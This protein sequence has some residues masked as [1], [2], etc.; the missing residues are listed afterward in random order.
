MPGVIW[1][2]V[3][4]DTNALLKLGGFCIIVALASTEC[5]PEKR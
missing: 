1:L 4:A 5:A 2:R 3:R